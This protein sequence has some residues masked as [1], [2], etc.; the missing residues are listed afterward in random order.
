MSRRRPGGFR[1]R[2]ERA[3][4]G[5]HCLELPGS[6]ERRL[7]DGHPWIYRDHI[8]TGFDAPSGSWVQARAGRWSG[9]GLW[10]AASPIALRVFSRERCP[11]EAWVRARVRDAW[12]SREELRRSGTTA[13]RWLFGEGDGLPGL[14][15]DLYG[16]HVVIVTYADALESLLPWVV[17]AMVELAP[18]EGILLKT[19]RERDGEPRIRALWGQ[20][21]A[22][23]LVVVEHGVKLEVDL[24]E[25]QKTGLFLDH[26]ENRRFI[27]AMASG[28]SLLNLFSYTGGFSIHAALGGA[29]HVTSVDVAPGAMAAA[30]SNFELN[31]LSPSQHDF[32]VGDV[33]EYLASGVESKWDIVVS[34]PPSFARSRVQL[35]VARSAYVRLHA[36][37]MLAVKPG[38]LLAAA[39]CTAQ[40]D[41]ASFQATLAEGA[42]KVRRRLQIIHEA[43]Q[44]LDHPVMAQHPEGRYLKFVLGRVLASV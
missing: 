40:M 41:P 24:L 38:G 36:A 28:R 39:S 13:Y 15:A 42:R 9:W 19:S 31:G 29:S 2:E 5:G 23:Q 26:R 18:L 25:G 35:E 34:D 43:G 33:F 44:P 1:G 27:G 16:R 32:V 20:L 10:D 37:A 8:P 6:L 4:S 12:S 21:P 17:A 7:L 22:G 3:G 11:D 30:K 14:T